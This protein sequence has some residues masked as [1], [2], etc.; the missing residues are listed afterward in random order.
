MCACSRVCV[1]ACA[2]VPARVRARLRVPR[3]LGSGYEDRGSSSPHPPNIGLFDSSRNSPSWKCAGRP[4]CAARQGLHAAQPSAS[5]SV[6]MHNARVPGSYN[7]M[8]SYPVFTVGHQHVIGYHIL[9]HM[10]AALSWSS[11]FTII[12]LYVHDEGAW[13]PVCDPLQ[14][15]LEKLPRFRKVAPIDWWCG[16]HCFLAA[17]RW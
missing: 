4:L 3:R 7:H 17:L 5:K 6:T 9:L 2:A 14:C 16:V 8:V 10:G 15:D 12:V 11:H 13:Q 1:L